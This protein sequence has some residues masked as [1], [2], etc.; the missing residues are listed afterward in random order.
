MSL[1]AY[2]PADRRRALALGH[3]LPDRANGAALFADISGFT[4]LTERLARALGPRLGAEELAHQLN[5]VYDALI[6]EVNRYHGSVVFFSGD[7]ITC[8]FAQNDERGM[9]NDE[10][11]DIAATSS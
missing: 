4:P 5:L 2:L 10:G 7:S 11:L 1:V 9:M 8:W 3:A 6:T